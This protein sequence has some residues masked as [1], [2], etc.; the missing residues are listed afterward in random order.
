MVETVASP[1]WVSLIER[2][3]VAKPVWLE[4]MLQAT[5]VFNLLDAILTLCVVL[6]GNASEANPLMAHALDRGP[7]LFTAS[8]LVLVSV[9]I[10]VLW[11]E[12]A[13]RLAVIGGVSVFMVYLLVMV[14][15]LQS[16][17]LLLAP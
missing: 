10:L 4:R 3:E 5:L 11:R 15:H 6:S 13:R 9:G 16:V 8:K 14:Y 17:Q 1:S 2:P 12:R 7:L